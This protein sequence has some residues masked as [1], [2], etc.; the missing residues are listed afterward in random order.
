MLDRRNVAGRVAVDRDEVGEQPRGV[1]R[2]AVSPD[3]VW[4]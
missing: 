1:H 4:R 3:A 2:E